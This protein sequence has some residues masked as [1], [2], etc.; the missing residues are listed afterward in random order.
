MFFNWNAPL[1]RQADGDDAVDI[2]SVEFTLTGVAPEKAA[3]F[4][5]I[6][7]PPPS[8]TISGNSVRGVGMAVADADATRAA[9]S[10]VATDPH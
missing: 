10:F 6:V 9:L 1:N 8:A 4:P 7:I 5:L 3:N 2:I